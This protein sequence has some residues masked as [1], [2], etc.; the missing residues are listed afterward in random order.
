MIPA[1]CYGFKALCLDIAR[2]RFKVLF[3]LRLANKRPHRAR[4]LTVALSAI[5]RWKSMELWHGS[6]DAATVGPIDTGDLI[7]FSRFRHG[8]ALFLRE[9]ERYSSK[10]LGREAHV[11]AIAICQ[12]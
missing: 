12:R 11:R 8:L 10:F 7:D 6:F 3:R 4:P 1:V 2:K 5:A 9:G